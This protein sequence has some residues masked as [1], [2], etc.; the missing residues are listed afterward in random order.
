[1][2]AVSIESIVPVNERCNS[3]SY[4]KYERYN[5]IHLKEHEI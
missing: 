1:M 2:K 4:D 3:K 5:D